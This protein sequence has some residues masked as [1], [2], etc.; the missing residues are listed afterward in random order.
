MTKQPN[1]RPRKHAY[2]AYTLYNMADLLRFALYLHLGHYIVKCVP[3]LRIFKKKKKTDRITPLKIEN[4]LHIAVTY[5]WQPWCPFS[6]IRTA[7]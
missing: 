4:A 7:T 6:F 1:R 5:L 3:S 2:N